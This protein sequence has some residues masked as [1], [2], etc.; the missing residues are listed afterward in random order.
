MSQRK[1]KL[2]RKLE[3]VKAQVKEVFVAEWESSWGVVKMNW[4]FLGLICILIFGVYLN[5]LK[6][7]FVS[8]DYATI[9]QNPL[10]GNLGYMFNK[11]NSMFLSNYLVFKLFGHGSSLPYHALSLRNNFV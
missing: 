4:K 10:I 9:T 8:D 7:D 6:G 1:K 3:K 2:E 5:S 11:G